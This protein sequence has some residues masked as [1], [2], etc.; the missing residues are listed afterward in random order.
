MDHGETGWIRPERDG[1][2][3]VVH[4]VPGAGRSEVVGPQHGKL[5]VR[6]AA[7]AMEGKANQALV[8][9]LARLL[10]I[11]KSRVQVRHGERSRSKVLFV[12]GVTVETVHQALGTFP[13]APRRAN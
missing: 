2:S 8:E 3:L 7:P 1:V 5:K 12:Q 11:P 4:V 13:N 9:F 10:H 6:V